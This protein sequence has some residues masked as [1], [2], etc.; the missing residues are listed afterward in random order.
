MK[1]CHTAFYREAAAIL[2]EYLSSDYEGFVDK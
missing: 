2:K 1:Y